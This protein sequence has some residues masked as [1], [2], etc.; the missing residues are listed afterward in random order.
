MKAFVTG[1][2]GFVGGHL[3]PRLLAEGHAVIALARSETAAERVSSLGAEVAH[4]DLADRDRLVDAMSD[5]D[6]VFHCAAIV[7][8]HVDTEDARA[9]NIVGT[10]NVVDAANEAP[11]RRL[12]HLSTESVLLDG[13][14][15][16]GV[17]E[18]LP[19]PDHGH[20]SVYAAT[21]AAAERI[22][23]SANGEQLETIAI[24]PRLIWGPGDTTWL[25]GLVQK[26]DAGVFRWVDGG[27]HLGSTCHV[28]NVVEAL[29]LASDRGVPGS[30]YFVTDG[31]PRPFREFAEAY[32]ATAGVDAGD[33]SVPGWLMGAMANVLE[34]IWRFLPT[35][36][37][38]P[39]CR[40]EAHMVSHPQVFDDSL[41]RSELG[42]R[43]VVTMNEGLAELERS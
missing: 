36:S 17:D 42:Y 35:N 20:L 39:V 24:R 12:V 34:R 26:V 23:R 19:V 41:A 30:V 37:P 38:P 25:P 11:A 1:G 22:V 4:G 10:A 32:L 21:K 43:P 28:R 40:V 7:G 15:L 5:S 8:S 27:R 33:R 14:P 2:S 6:V 29:V 16:D 31:P 13:R 3:I 9:T 18:S